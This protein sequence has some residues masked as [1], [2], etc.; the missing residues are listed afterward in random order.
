MPAAHNPLVIK[1]QHKNFQQCSSLELFVTFLR[2]ENVK[3]PFIKEISKTL[4]DVFTWIAS[5]QLFSL[6]QH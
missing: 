2:M 4:K 3:N 6:L 5:E 1:N